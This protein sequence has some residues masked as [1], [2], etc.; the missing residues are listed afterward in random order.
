MRVLIS[1]D[2]SINVRANNLARLYYRQEFREE[3]DEALKRILN[4]NSDVSLELIK[5]GLDMNE[6][7]KAEKVIREAETDEELEQAFLEMGIDWNMILDVL[8]P[9]KYKT[10]YPAF[11]TMQVIWAMAMAEKKAQQQD[12]TPYQ[13]WLEGVA[14]F[15]VNDCPDDFLREVEYGFFRYQPEKEEK[16]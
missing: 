4:H 12:L 2:V 7:I 15:D 3:L 5:K 11:E 1:K 6:V 14:D 9:D 13:A 16:Q 8:T 10:K